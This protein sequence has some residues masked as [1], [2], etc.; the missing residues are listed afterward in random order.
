VA[1]NRGVIEDTDISTPIAQMLHKD[2]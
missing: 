2:V 1:V